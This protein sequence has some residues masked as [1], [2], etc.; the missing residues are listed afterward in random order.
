MV[1]KL[2]IIIDIIIHATEDISKILHSFNKILE[3]NE[4]DFN[5][6]NTTGYF[7]NPIILLNVKLVKKQSKIFMKRFL[8]LLSKNQINQLIEEIEER[9]A[10]SKF[11]LRLDKQELVKGELILS[12]KD[13]IKIKIH[14]PIY[15][16]KDSIEKFSKVFHLN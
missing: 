9:T 2:E 5:I 1:E 10:D 11:H 7:G 3:I 6:T 16:K 4:E 8:K 14:T 12:E 15:K 13:T